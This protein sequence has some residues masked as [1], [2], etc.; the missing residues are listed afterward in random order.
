M[1]DP[2]SRLIEAIDSKDPEGIRSAYAPRAR[3]VAMTPETFRVAEGADAVASVL[4]E[5]FTTWE[6]AP[7]YA[8]LGT[9]RH[10]DRAVVE[11]E[12]TSTFEGTPWVVRQA[13]VLQVGTDG[14]TE[15]RVYCCGPRAGS[16]ELASAYTEAER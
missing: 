8:F 15:H 10:G 4:A 6:E 1:S 11:F 13:H 16:P 7:S 12:R 14:I 5:W 9:I 3:L 2:V